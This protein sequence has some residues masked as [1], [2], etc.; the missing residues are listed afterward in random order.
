[1]KTEKP[2]EQPTGTRKICF[3]YSRVSSLIQT[4]DDK[5]GIERQLQSAQRVVAM[6]P[7]WILDDKLS[8]SDLGLS[9]YHKKNLT[10][11][12]KLG[13][14]VKALKDGKIPAG[15]IMLID[16]MSRLTRAEVMTAFD[17]FRD[18]I[19]DGME[20]YVCKSDRHYTKES[21]NNLTDLIIIL[22][23][24]TAAHD[25][26]ANLGKNV[27]AA[28]KIKK[29]RSAESGKPYQF[30]IG[31][32]LIWNNETKG[33]DLIPEKVKAVKRIFELACMGIGIRG[34][35]KRL[36]EEKVPVMTNYDSKKI[37]S[38]KGWR[39]ATIRRTL[40]EKKVLGYNEHMN[41]PVLMYPPIITEKVYYTAQAKINER[42]TQK[43]YGRGSDKP[44]NL[45]MGIGKCS[46]C[47]RS[48]IIYNG[49]KRKS[50]KHYKY[51]MCGGIRD[52][53]C[54]NNQLPQDQVEESFASMLSGSAFVAA[55]AE[56]KPEAGSTLETL[57][58][59]IADTNT[60]LE[61]FAADYEKSPSDML[62][63][64]MTKTE[65]KVK[66]L[67]QELETATTAQVGTSPL[68]DTRNELL[69]ILY[70]GWY[71]VDVRLKLRELIRAV[72]DK[73]IVNGPD[74]CYTIHWKNGDTPTHVELFRKAYKIDDIL[75]P[76]IP[77]WEKEMV[78]SGEVIRKQ[79]EEKKV[80]PHW[81][82]GTFAKMTAK[83][84][85]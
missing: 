52:G 45:F 82:K 21:L 80:E 33:Y 32:W 73:I 67:N 66:E 83:N 47:G 31:G 76:C 30:K 58:G 59:K 75:I 41:P 2:V 84:K 19:R 81:T 46:K 60:R 10:E 79:E 62:A 51:L 39:S 5:T 74:K 48:M 78:R 15:R 26:A 27:A 42:R 12:A 38:I 63:G 36:N 13:A 72:V 55:Y 28:C 14:L 70:K 54:S 3:S 64:L 50:G 18:L 44:D 16:D 24:I 85:V 43:Y 61:R 37:K 4:A 23:D 49:K 7:G 40:K 1:M 34:I 56:T 17:L 29:Q 6:H 11:T 65:A 8:I 22:V 69:A 68:T 25:Y 20:I 57:K 71:D 53:I 9:G 77:E 35:A